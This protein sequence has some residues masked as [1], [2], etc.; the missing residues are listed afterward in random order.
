MFL[1]KAELQEA[2]GYKRASDQITWLKSYG[3]N[4]VLDR[5]RHPKVLRSEFERHL[6]SGE[7]TK[8]DGPKLGHIRRAS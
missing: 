5:Y 4:Y 3:I 6:S 8:D 1:T 7:A 2:S